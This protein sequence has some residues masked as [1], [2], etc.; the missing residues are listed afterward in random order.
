M[1]AFYRS[2]F[3]IK[4]EKSPLIDTVAVSQALMGSVRSRTG[5]TR[6]MLAISLVSIA[7]GM[8]PVRAE[9]PDASFTI[10]SI[11]P[12][13]LTH[14][15]AG[16]LS[17]GSHDIAQL[18]CR[19]S[20]NANIIQRIPR[21]PQTS[22]CSRE[23]E[24]RQML[25]EMIR[26]G[27]ASKLRIEEVAQAMKLHF[28]IA[29]TQYAND[30]LLRTS[31]ELSRQKATQAKLI[32]AGVSIPDA[33]LIDRLQVSWN[34]QNIENQSKEQ[35]LRLQLSRLIGKQN[36]CSYVPKTES[37]L[38]PSDIDVCQYVQ[39]AMACRSDL[40]LLHKLRSSMN[41]DLLPLWD[42]LVAALTGV[43]GLRTKDPT[44][45]SRR[46]GP[47]IET[48]NCV[49]ASTGSIVSFMND[50]N[51]RK[52]KSKSPMRKSVRLL[53]VGAIRTSSFQTGTPGFSNW[54]FWGT[55]SRAT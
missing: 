43:P 15:E 28:G 36:A 32:E 37:T 8:C 14:T 31:Q 52:W 47:V 2:D 7:I 25:L 4:M 21:S 34:D 26:S 44:L 3:V 50:P 45:L 22:V 6:R 1:L 42:E 20:A 13:S 35:T 11:E 51:R 27:A 53:F 10:R 24:T 12:Y 16:V 17:L 5:K 54:N 49:N 39:R 48:Q 38:A 29:A 33:I 30:L 55:R 19:C 40:Q 23:D 46:F 9:E 18:A 41:E